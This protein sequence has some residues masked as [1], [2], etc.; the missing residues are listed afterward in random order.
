MSG[1]DWAVSMQAT[2]QSCGCV[3]SIQG[4]HWPSLYGSACMYVNIVLVRQNSVVHVKVDEHVHAA[5][6]ARP[7]LHAMN[8]T[9]GLACAE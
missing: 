9:T 4:G 1:Q 2:V 8:L 6:V 3:V 5:V 7:L